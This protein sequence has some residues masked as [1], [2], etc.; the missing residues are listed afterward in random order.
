MFDVGQK[1]TVIAGNGIAYDGVILARAAGDSGPG[2]YKVALDGS[3]PEQL[4]QW[5]KA[6]D[7]FVR[8]KSDDATQDVW[9]NLAGR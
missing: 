6:G 9:E 7:V 1:V 8:E 5:H 3:G 4:G 2:A